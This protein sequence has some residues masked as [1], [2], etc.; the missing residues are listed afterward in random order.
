MSSASEALIVRSASPMISMVALELEES[1][2]YGVVQR[3]ASI[4]A[5]PQGDVTSANQTN[6]SSRPQMCIIGDGSCSLK[7]AVLKE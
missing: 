1:L 6:P 5:Y 3:V 2:L 7:P 4:L